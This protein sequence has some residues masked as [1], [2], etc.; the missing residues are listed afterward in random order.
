[1]T[2]SDSDD[3]EVVQMALSALSQ[4][5]ARALASGRPVVLVENDELVRITGSEKIVLKKLPARSK[6]LNPSKGAAN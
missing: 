4:A 2:E 3:A 6:I 5:Q 1:M